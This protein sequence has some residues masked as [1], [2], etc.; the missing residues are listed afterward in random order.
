LD[1]ARALKI[2]VHA[3]TPDESH[4]GHG[5]RVLS[6][7]VATSPPCPPISAT[8]AGNQLA[9]HEPYQRFNMMKLTCD[10]M[11]AQP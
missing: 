11:D 6:P 3:L 8:R 4:G 2:R 5:N 1:G 10:V 9:I 7:P